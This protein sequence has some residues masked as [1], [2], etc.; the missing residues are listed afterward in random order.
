MSWGTTLEDH[1]PG[2]TTCP[3]KSPSAG[4]ANTQFYLNI[5]IKSTVSYYIPSSCGLETD[6][7]NSESHRS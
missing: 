5:S 6:E 7:D 2:V 1:C 4:C 3:H